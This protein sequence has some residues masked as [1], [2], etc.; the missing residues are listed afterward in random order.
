MGTKRNF[1]AKEDDTEEIAIFERMRW[2][3]KREECMK[4]AFKIKGIS[5][6]GKK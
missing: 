5:K 2:G 3:K 6:I 1:I 4:D